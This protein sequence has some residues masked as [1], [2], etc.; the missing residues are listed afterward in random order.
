MLLIGELVWLGQIRFAF[1]VS[2]GKSLCFCFGMLERPSLFYFYYTIDEVEIQK[3][4]PACLF[5]R[6]LSTIPSEYIREK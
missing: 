5:P 3:R 1:E 4:P 2:G 6:F